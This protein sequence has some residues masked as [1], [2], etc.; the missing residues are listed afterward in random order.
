M[1]TIN[2]TILNSAYQVAKDL[3]AHI[4]M[5]YI[6]PLGSNYA[7]QPENSQLVVITQ[8]SDDDLKA[9][10]EKYKKVIKIPNIKL[11]RYGLVKVAMAY[12]VSTGLLKSKDKVV[13]I[14]GTCE[15]MNLDRI[16]YMEVGKENE[17][18]TTKKIMTLAESVNPLVFEQLLNLSLELAINGREGKM[19]GTIFVLGDHE[20]VLSLSKQL[21]F[22]PFKGYPEE[23]RNIFNPDLKETIREF[24]AL[25][26]AFVLSETGT[27]I[28]AGRFLGVSGNDT[29]IPSGLGTRHMAA[30]G[31][32]AL[33]NAIAIVISEST[34][35]IRI[36]KDGTTL[37]EIEKP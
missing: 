1:K 4:I 9:L 8:K 17:G 37:L 12:S 11:G 14:G 27:L 7:P 5:I 18:I 28:T 10:Q 22:N 24:S 25:D 2:K 26:G 15:D 21:I 6:D 19:I 23:E 16:L 20:K 36:F 29:E 33:T 35:N 13:F 34:G 30:A 31:I 32:T 3:K